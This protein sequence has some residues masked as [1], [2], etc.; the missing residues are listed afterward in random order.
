MHKG[1]FVF[2]S[3]V[4][5][6]AC[7]PSTK[8]PDVSHIVVNATI[9]RFDQDFFNVKI[10]VPERMQTIKEK[11][12]NLYGLFLYNT[13]IL[14]MAQSTGNLQAA[15]NEFTNIHQPLYDSTQLL[16]K[17]LKW[18]EKDFAKG[19]QL[20]KYYFPN[21]IV[22]KLFAIVD[23]FNPD[24]PMSYY[25]IAYSKDTLLIS[26]QMFLGKDFSA[27]DP[28]VYFDYLRERFDKKYILKNAFT[29]IINTQFKPLD[30]DAPL[31][32]QMIDAGKR[33]YLLNKVLP[34]TPEEVKIGYTKKQLS[35]CYENENNI[36]THFINR[37]L[38]FNVEPTLIKEYI[39]E[40]PFTKEM[41]TG[42]PGNIGAFVGWQI[43]KKYMEENG[44]VSPSKLMAMDNKIIYNE[45]K[46]KP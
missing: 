21:F 37:N 26:L 32:E 19:F 44:N 4:F 1:L 24:A 41:G 7:S 14:D 30:Q 40:N 23:G 3:I 42:T 36:W 43:V 15:V 34:N 2:L 9:Q 45:T 29:N 39:G 16:Y 38:L 6:I 46:Y 22:P 20:Y 11:Y 12:D 18:L 8:Q 25:G 33:I 35:D 5:F 13:G 31:V 17:D 10:P 28:Q 27:Y